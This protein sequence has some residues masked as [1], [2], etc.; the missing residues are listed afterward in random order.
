MTVDARALR[1]VAGHF[2]TGVTVVTTTLGDGRPC[3]L[4]V[5]SFT[6]VSL[7]PPVVLVCVARSARAHA[8]VEAT[9]RYLVNMLAEGQERVARV[10]ASRSEDKFADVAWH[11]S[12]GG[13][14]IFDGAHAWIECEVIARY[15]GGTTHTIYVGRVTALGTRR[16]RPL[17]FHGGAYVRLATPG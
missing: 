17:V 8:C 11:R 14:P 4:T 2:P 16:G 5:N 7:E 10:F 1:R 9:G 12:P 3:G 13:Q 6:S 15:P